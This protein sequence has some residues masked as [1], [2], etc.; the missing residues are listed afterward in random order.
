M[1]LYLADDVMLGDLLVERE[2]RGYE[3]GQLLLQLIMGHQ[4]THGPQSFRHSQ[5]QLEHTTQSGFK[6]S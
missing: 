5:T 4:V 1:N 3:F 2:D 6:V